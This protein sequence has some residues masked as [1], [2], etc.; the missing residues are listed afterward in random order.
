[1]RKQINKKYF[2]V[3]ILQNSLYICTII[4]A[5]FSI[6]ISNFFQSDRNFTNNN[7]P[8]LP[9]CDAHLEGFFFL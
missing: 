9:L 8:S 3:T 5:E 4:G 2:K 1:M 7:T 6:Q